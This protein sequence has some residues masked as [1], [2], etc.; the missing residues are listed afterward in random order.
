[1]SSRSGAPL[2]FLEEG[3]VRGWFM[4]LDLSVVRAARLSV[5]IAPPRGAPAGPA[6]SARGTRGTSRRLCL[7]GSRLRGM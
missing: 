6:R 2:E 5:S 1:M 4:V 3:D 7:H